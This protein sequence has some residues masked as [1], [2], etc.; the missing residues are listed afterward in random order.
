M[1]PWGAGLW[2]RLGL[3]LKH[4]LH[5]HLHCPFSLFLMPAV[6]GMAAQQLGAGWGSCGH[7]VGFS[8]HINPRGSDTMF[9]WLFHLHPALIFP[10][11]S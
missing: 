7:R 2:F 1:G 6:M 10:E 11:Q 3:A 8:H 9:G 4:A 5:K